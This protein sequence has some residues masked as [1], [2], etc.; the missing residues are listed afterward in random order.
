MRT[1]VAIGGG[2]LKDLETFTLD[3]L[4]VEYAGKARPHALFIPTAS[5][6]SEDYAHT[7]ERVYAGELGCRTDALRLLGSAPSADEIA[8][9]IAWADL[10]YVG[11]GNTLRMMR[12]WRA[13]GVDKLLI[14][15]CGR[16]T[17][18][19][20]LS[21]GAICWFRYGHS[22]SKKF[23][24]KGGPW[25]YIR[26]RGIGIIPAT[27]CPHH[28]SDERRLG[29]RKTIGRYGGVGIG[30]DDC[31]ALVLRDGVYSIAASREDASAWKLLKVNGE[32]VSREFRH[33]D[34]VD[35][36]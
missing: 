23:S 11:G 25:E 19:S 29:F 20:G 13:L 30:L 1:I 7:F 33:G 8:E 2:E 10:V 5:G 21:A 36:L 35:I 22:D 26:L 6:D 4:I 28:T 24:A 34:V 12:R 9:K 27:V 17:V 18:L 3:K 16:G 31:C 15:A 14:Q 32:V